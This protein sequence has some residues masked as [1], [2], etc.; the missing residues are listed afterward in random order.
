MCACGRAL[1]RQTDAAC[2]I[3][4]LEARQGL[5]IREAVHDCEVEGCTG[6]AAFGERYCTKCTEE[7]RSLS[8]MA[9]LKDQRREQRRIHR[10]EQLAAWSGFWTLCRRIR[11]RLWIANMV[12]VFGAL[13]YL[14]V[15]YGYAFLEW[16][17][18]GGLQ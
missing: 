1:W 11:A 18:N 8:A 12:F 16:L 7:I 14:V 13:M 10:A 4:E 9:L 3:C 6:L 5:R 17:D 15:V 2:S